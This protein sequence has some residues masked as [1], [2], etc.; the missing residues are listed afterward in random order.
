MTTDRVVD[1]PEG[2][3]PVPLGVTWGLF[4]AWAVHDLEELCTM[5]G[6]VDR[7]RPRLEHDMPWVP[8]AVWDRMSVSQEHAATA[9]GVMGCVVASASARGARGV[10]ARWRQRRG[11]S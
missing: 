8:A 9:I 5:A 3:R 4:A 11:R 7:A 1:L 6:W 2:T 10:R